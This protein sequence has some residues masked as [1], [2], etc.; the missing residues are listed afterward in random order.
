MFGKIVDGKLIIVGKKIQIKSGWITSP[1]EKDLKANGYKEIVYQKE[2]EFDIDNEKINEQY[3]DDKTQ[4]IV[5]Y[6]VTK[7][8]NEEFNER[9]KFKIYSEISKINV[10]DIVNAIIKINSGAKSNEELNTLTEIKNT[11]DNL[12]KSLKEVK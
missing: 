9:V 10:L 1:T 2:P 11:I 5:S 8:T 3:L 12:N 6:Y 7:L 4:I